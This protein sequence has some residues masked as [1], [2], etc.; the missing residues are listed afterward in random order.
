MHRFHDI[1]GVKVFGRWTKAGRVTTDIDIENFVL[2]INEENLRKYV[3]VYKRDLELIED[4][5]DKLPNY[6]MFNYDELDDFNTYQHTQ[7]HDINYEAHIPFGLVDHC[8]ILFDKCL[9]E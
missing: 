8:K 3:K 6:T 4:I 7:K 2:P 5:T 9:N 1:D